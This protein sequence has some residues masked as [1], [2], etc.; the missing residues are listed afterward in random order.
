MPPVSL[1]FFWHQHQPWY[2]DR[3]GGETLMPWVRLHATK[4][5][6]GM[7]WHIKEVPEFRCTINLVPSLLKQLIAYTEEGATDR[8]LDVSRIPADGLGETDGR[9]LLDHFFMASVDNM[10]RPYARYFELW[11]KRSAAVDSVD[12]ALKRFSER[13]LRDLQVWHNLTWFHPILFEIDTDLKAFLQKG[14]NWTETEKQW[15]LRKQLDVLK[16]ILPLHRYGA[17]SGQ[18]ELT[19]T[20][21]Y[22]PILPLL[23][24]KR[25]ARQAMPGCALPKHLEPYKE[26]AA[27]PI[28][29][30]GG[31][32]SSAV[33]R[34]TERAV[35]FRGIC[36]ARDHSCHR[37][38]GN[39]VDCHR[40]RNS[41]RVDESGWVSRDGN[42]FLRNP[43][44]LYRPW[45]VEE[46]GRS[47][48][49][50]FRD[51]ALS[52]LIGFHY[53]RMN[54]E[55][56]VSDLLAKVNAIGRAT[57]QTNGDRPALVPIILD[58]EN[59]WEYY[60]D[61]GV[62]FLRT[63]Y[64]TCVSRNH[65]RPVR[66]RDHLRDYHATDRISHLFAGS[67][68]SHNFGIWIGHAE[69]HA[70]WDLLHQTREF[71]KQAEWSGNSPVTRCNKPGRKFISPKAAIGS[72]GTETT[73][74][75]HR[76]RCSINCFANI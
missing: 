72:G 56:A 2:P 60:R 76:T 75:R 39:R 54:P 16:Q 55:H 24:D 8:H 50:V 37:R 33:R 12:R 66:V 68:I 57:A 71:L 36:L 35:A 34:K 27:I 69:D 5:Y 13:D 32:A 67:W 19:T 70:A 30:G 38:L 43:E 52:D 61:G 48:Q 41:R 25:S 53:Q 59:C 11:Q 31:C 6:W 15:L 42:G 74:R 46:Q 49:I 51:H 40:R 10:I 23:W 21:F 9:Y 28:A 58:G 1:A 18:V 29:E 44:M 17:E 26:D 73:I 65:I 63:L 20:P 47:L 45:R 22:H 64:Q 4:D 14:Q 7:A 3:I 62:Q